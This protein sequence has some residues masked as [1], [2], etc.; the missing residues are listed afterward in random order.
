MTKPDNNPDDDRPSLMPILT[1][2]A[3]I[4]VALVAFGLL[5]L[6]RGDETPDEGRVGIAA[7]G[8]NDALQRGDYADFR[9]Y[10][11][12]AEQGTEARVLGDQRQSTTAK[13][14]RFVDDVA[15]IAVTGDRATAT[16]VYHFERSPDD[17][18]KT[19]ATFVRENGEW[20]VCSPGPR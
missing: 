16:V 11:C 2:L 12:L 18:I 13:G 3:V 14:A 9:A 20:K 8:Q 17:K 7:V 15:D 19:P 10:T 5:R 4:V 6:F 1:A